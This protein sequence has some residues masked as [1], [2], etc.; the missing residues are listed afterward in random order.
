MDDRD[1]HQHRYTDPSFVKLNGHENANR[2]HNGLPN[3]KG[4]PYTN[5]LDYDWDVAFER[6]ERERVEARVKKDLEGW[7][8]GHGYVWCPL[9]GCDLPSP[10]STLILGRSLASHVTL[11]AMRD[12]ISA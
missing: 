1:D 11:F 9:P 3:G 8:G 10:F 5:G 2:I 4:Q 6:E 7:R 12:R